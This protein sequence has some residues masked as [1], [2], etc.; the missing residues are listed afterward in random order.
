[1]GYHACV[2]PQQPEQ[3]EAARH[4]K[5]SAP[6]GAGVV[7]AWAC[8]HSRGLVACLQARGVVACIVHMKLLLRGMSEY[9]GRPAVVY[10]PSCTGQLHSVFVG[11]MLAL[12]DGACWESRWLSREWHQ[13]AP[14]PLHR[15]GCWLPVRVLVMSEH[16]LLSRWLRPGMWHELHSTTK[17]CVEPSVVFICRPCARQFVVP[18]QQRLYSQL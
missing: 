1:V 12:P 6:A 7:C 14:A 8:K 13:P 15:H 3:M 9:V 18:A 16:L 5:C 2:Q 4:C 17:V 10:S 11:G